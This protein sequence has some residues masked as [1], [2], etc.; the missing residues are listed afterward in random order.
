MATVFVLWVYDGKEQPEMSYNLSLNTII[1]VLG[2]GCKSALVLVIGE[3]I[4]QLKWLW[5]QDPGQSQN[6][7]Q[8]VGIQRFDAA[9]RGPLGSLMIIFHY[10]ARSIVSLG[11]TI[12]VLL[13]AFD[14][15]MQQIIRYPIKSIP[16][17]NTT[18]SAAAPQSRGLYYTLPAD[19]G[20]L[21]NAFIQGVFSS[22]SF[23]VAPQ[24]STGN[25]SWDTFSSVGICS[26][27]ADAI[28]T[29]RLDCDLPAATKPF[30]KTCN[31]SLPGTAAYSFNAVLRVPPYEYG[32]V[33]E[34]PSEDSPNNDLELK[35]PRRII[36]KPHDLSDKLANPQDGYYTLAPGNLP[37]ITFAGVKNPLATVAY[38]ELALNESRK[39]SNAPLSDIIYFKNVTGC[40]LSTCRRDYYIRVTDGLPRI[41]TNNSD[42]GTVYLKNTTTENEDG[43]TSDFGTLCWM[44][45]PLDPNGYQE[46]YNFSFCNDQMLGLATA[47]QYLPHTFDE[48]IFLEGAPRWANNGDNDWTRMEFFQRVGF[49]KIME[50]IAASLTK[51]GLQRTANTVNGK[52]TLTKA[53]VNVRW[54]WIIYPVALVV[55]AVVFLVVTVI[56]NKRSN[57]PL[58]KSS[59]LASY[60]HGLER[61]DDEV[62]D[63]YLTTSAMEKKA[64]REEVRLQFSENNGRLVLRQQ[65]PPGFPKPIP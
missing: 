12:I 34:D 31:V 8:L 44:P 19:Q 18:A 60:Y 62:Y 39:S 26:S 55:A 54:L 48:T 15:F 63:K 5:F 65:E 22:R 2:T 37:N 4:S 24:C 1:S 30:N 13:L 25:C 64:E 16:D 41:R 11:A 29:A 9:S 10:R 59:A 35:L 14:P 43:S 53:F 40:S 3:A 32:V 42:F 52:V 57:L 20:D 50:N 6:Q 45:G 56:L 23:D 46:S 17:M 58:W 49:E 36:W 47:R 21:N 51:F 28:K 7:N 33:Y 61:L 27:C 38:V